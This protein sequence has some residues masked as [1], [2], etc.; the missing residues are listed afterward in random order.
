MQYLFFDIECADGGKSTI[1]SF[2]YVIADMKFNILEQ[3]DIL[4]NPEGEF[5]LEGRNGKPDLV[6]AYPKE[7]FL[8]APTF[9]KVYDEIKELLESKQFYV[10]GHSVEND[11]QFLNM[12]CKR[13]G[14]PPLE[15]EYF[16]TQR[17]YK[18][19]RARKQSISL[20]N[21]LIELGLE[22]EVRYH[23]SDEDARATMLVLKALLEKASK[24]FVQYAEIAY[25]CTG[26]TFDFYW[27]WNGQSMDRYSDVYYVKYTKDFIREILPGEENYILRSNENYVNFLRYVAK[28]APIGEASNAFEGKS[29]CISLNYESRHYREMLRLVGMIKAAGGSYTRKATE[30]NVFVTWNY[31]VKGEPTDKCSRLSE[32]RNASEPLE[33]EI[34]D[35]TELLS[36]LST[37]VD[38]LSELP[39]IREDYFLTV[40]EI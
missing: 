24:S 32:I 9:D 14:M 10:V 16:D 25:D 15:F 7:D 20:Q 19:L 4:V 28:G 1:C 13:Y 27:G 26:R 40:R 11:I 35:F 23:R 12:S 3:R 8:A 39:E 2:G 30:A 18:D 29:V 34:I 17:T 37:N 5:C 38:E 21:A 22:E 36:R 33:I 6:L 31:N